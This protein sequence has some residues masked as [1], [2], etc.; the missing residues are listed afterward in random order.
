[1][2]LRCDPRTSDLYNFILYIDVDHIHLPQ[3]Q[4]RIQ[5]QAPSAL[6]HSPFE[7]QKDSKMPPL[8]QKGLLQDQKIK[9]MGLSQLDAEGG[10]WF[11]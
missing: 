10:I 11:S 2:V 3:L 7:P 4:H 8:Q 6:R 9:H 1:M 5:A